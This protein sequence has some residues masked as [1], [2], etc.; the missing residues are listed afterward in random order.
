MPN[1]SSN[2]VA[3]RYIPEVTYGVTPGTGN[4]NDLRMT[5]ESLAYAIQTDSS[6]EIRSDRQTTDLVP[7]GASASGGLNFEVS[8]KEF[9][10]LMQAVFMDTW[11]VYGTG[12]VSA[13]MSL[14]IDSAAGTLTASVAPTG[15]SAFL[16]GPGL[17]VGQFFRLVAPGDA[18]NGAI[19]R[20]A[21]R[22]STIITV[23]TAT[24]IPGTGS[25]AG[26]A[27]CTIS[28]SRLVNGTTPRSFSIEKGLLDVNQ[29]FMFRG[30]NASKLSLSF[31]SGSIVTGSLDFMGKDS[32]RGTVTGMP[33]S[34]VAS[35]AYDVVNAVTGVGSL[36]E[37]GVA[38]SGTFIKSLKLDIDNKLR[39]QDAIGVYGY[40]G[41][42]PGTLAVSGE[43]EVY[44]SDGALYDKF[45]NN[46]V[47]SVNWTMKDG[48]GNG[49]AIAL[50][51][52][53]Y[54]DAK[55]QAGGLDQDVM[56]SLPFT[57]LMDSVTGKS[58]IL[59]RFGAAIV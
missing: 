52:I 44:L 37:N 16:S 30:M 15:A 21:S 10:T 41:I 19:L 39:G 45:V 24:P 53:K 56:L 6:K 2:R 51:K 11:S 31:Q 58:V 33:G 3:L 17:A 55:V 42:A 9:D 28:S 40:A 5:G 29:F 22:T 32:V 35:A 48:S 46:T 34:P 25:R 49:Y 54:S 4:P 38:M 26:V 23:S 43:M 27:N 7:V 13:T 12:G 47:S 20:V 8:Y 36:M 18:A 1:A 57:A 59:D 50:P 14:T